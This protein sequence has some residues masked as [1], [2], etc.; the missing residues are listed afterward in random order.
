MSAY[1]TSAHA[2]SGKYGIPEMLK[3]DLQDSWTFSSLR[4]L[5]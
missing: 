2:L 1:P 3:H 5:R 4:S